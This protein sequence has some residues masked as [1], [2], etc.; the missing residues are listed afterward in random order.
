MTNLAHVLIGL[1]QTLLAVNGAI[2][3]YG[4][5]DPDP[6]ADLQGILNPIRDP[7]SRSSPTATPA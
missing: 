1:R 2:T 3:Q 6:G 4:A 5:A 7:P